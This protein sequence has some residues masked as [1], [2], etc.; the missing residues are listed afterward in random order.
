MRRTAQALKLVTDASLR[1]QNRPP[2]EL[3]AYGMQA[4]LELIQKVAG[5]E[6][7]GVVDEYPAPAKLAPVS[8]TLSRIN[9]LLGSSFTTQE[10]QDVFRR[11]D[12]PCTTDGE[13][14]TVTPPF[15]RTDLVIP[16]DLAEEVGRISGY[17]RITPADLP[18]TKGESD[19][20]RYRGIERM[21]DQLVEQGF[22]E[23]STQSFATEGDIY[24]ANPLD[25]T[26]PALR[27]SLEENLTDALE[28]A[29][30]YAPLVLRPGEHP[31][32]FEVGIVFPKVGEYIE[33]RMTETAWEGVPTHDNLSVAKLEEYGKGYEPKHYELS[34]YKPFSAYPFVLRDIALWAPSEANVRL[35]MSYIKD[36]IG[37]LLKRI[38]LFDT[39][40]KGGR[41]SYAFR[42]VFESH[43]RTLTDEDVNSIMANIS[44]ALTHKGYEIR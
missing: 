19:Q 2:P 23:V 3:C 25:K 18:S 41:T 22:T 16:E 42:L 5:G 27:T 37:T 12:L 30:R 6:V 11:L 4:V 38:D 43:E 34:A 33:L 10:V 35:T 20:A 8:T 14:F 39:F 1:F 29:K 21:K 28:R 9:G 17:E 13:I 15:E 44:S 24:L 7:A 40:E 31:R 32:L 26:K 36:E